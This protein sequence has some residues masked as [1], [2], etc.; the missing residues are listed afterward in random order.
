M[1]AS[2]IVG[3]VGTGQSRVPPVTQKLCF[4]MGPPGDHPLDWVRGPGRT[5][6]QSGSSWP[7]LEFYLG[8]GHAEL[9][10]QGS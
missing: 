9:V 7:D 5:A 2:G 4:A 3:A 8:K 10:A 1:T 6:D